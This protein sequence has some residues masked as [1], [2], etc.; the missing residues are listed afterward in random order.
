MNGPFTSD[1]NKAMHTTTE[2]DGDKREKK[3]EKE[4]CRVEQL[5]QDKENPTDCEKRIIGMLN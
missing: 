4:K 3:S 2:G 5:S 1:K